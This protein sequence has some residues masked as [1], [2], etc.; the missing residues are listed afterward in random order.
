VFEETTMNRLTRCLLIAGFAAAPPTFGVALPTTGPAQPLPGSEASLVGMQVTDTVTSGSATLVPLVAADV[1]ASQASAADAN[2]P[3]H[4]GTVGKPMD[5]I[6]FVAR[7]TERARKE[8]NS[9]RDAL[10]QLA[11]PDLKRMAERLVADHNDANAK[12]A[13][14]AEQKLWP[15]PAPEAHETPPAGTAS[16]DFDSRWTAEMIAAHERSVALYSAQAQGG[17]DVD[18]RKHARETLPTIQNHLAELRRLQK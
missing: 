9:A 13:K 6:T 5:D 14:L 4:G 2:A 3:A 7:A 8:M 11:D 10:P 1:S 18:L 12:L 16:H 15:V 17:E